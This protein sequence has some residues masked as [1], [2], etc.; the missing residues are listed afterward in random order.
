MEIKRRDFLK[1]VAGGAA[2]ALAQ[3]AMAL[4]REKKRIPEAV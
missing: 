2:L 4:A 3:P 1:T